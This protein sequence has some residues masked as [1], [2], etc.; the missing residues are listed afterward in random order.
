[1]PA[2]VVSVDAGES[3]GYLRL[4]RLDER[5][6]RRYFHRSAGFANAQ[7]DRAQAAVASGGNRHAVLHCSLEVLGRDFNFVLAGRNQAKTE[8][9]RN[10]QWW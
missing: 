10:Y 9:G 3:V 4:C 7:L 5:S 1:M 6:V 2:K 8:R